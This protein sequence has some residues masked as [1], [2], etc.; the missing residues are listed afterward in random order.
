MNTAGVF[1]SIKIT[2]DAYRKR[3][4]DVQPAKFELSP[5]D[6]GWSYAEVYAHIFDLS[7]LSL[8]AIDRC[9]SDEAR[10]RK[11]PFITRAILFFG[12]FPPTMKFKVPKQFESR[13]R[14]IS[15]AEAIELMDEFEQ[16]LLPYTN[17]LNAAV[18]T[19]KAAHPKLGYL[20]AA[21]WLRFIEIHLKHHLKQLQRID[22]QDNFTSLRP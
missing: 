6:G 9:L 4:E 5:P 7:I 18:A 16:K 22:K 8:E 3:L 1:S 21:Q 2:T 10:Q 20:N 11:T 13:V 14:K 15:I 12:A 19:Q 17:K